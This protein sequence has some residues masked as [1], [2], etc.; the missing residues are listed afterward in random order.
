MTKLN[1]IIAVEKG[2]KASANRKFTDI[3]RETTKT[4]L[5]SGIARTYQPKDD[6]GDQLPSES[7]LV[8]TNIED[9]L[10]EAADTLTELFDVTLTKEVANQKA[11]ANVVVDGKTIVKDAP[12]SYLLFLEKQLIDLQ[13]FVSSLPVLD[14]AERW[15]KDSNANAWATEPTRT[16]RSKKVPRNHVKAEATDRHPAQ[17]ELFH[18]DVI[19][20]TWTTVKYSGA[21]EKSRANELSDRVSKLLTA[22]KFAREEANSADISDEK[23]GSE[24]FDY[25]FAK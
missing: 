19:V 15:S 1:Q 21:I 23:T 25:L 16:V 17:V 4:P 6:D 18:E 8:Q 13:K 7:T 10:T 2:L 14:P 5:L 20:G 24:V 9:L 11:K 3:H 22:V 12:V